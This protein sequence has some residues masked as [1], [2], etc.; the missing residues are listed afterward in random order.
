VHYILDEI[1]M[2]GMV[3]ET[4]IGEVLEAVVE[5]NQA[6]GSLKDMSR[7]RRQRRKGGR[8]EGRCSSARVCRNRAAAAAFLPAQRRFTATLAPQTRRDS[9]ATCSLSLQLEAR[10]KGLSIKA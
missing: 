3:L 7:E 9:L 1:V 10:T 4:N 6:R 2:G 8:A 5:M